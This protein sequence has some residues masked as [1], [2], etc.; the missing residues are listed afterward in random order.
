M[1]LDD[2]IYSK[3]YGIFSAVLS[4]KDFKKCW[5]RNK[6]ILFKNED[7]QQNKKFSLL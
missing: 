2:I 4:R 5:Y 7:S 3:E 6:D 1:Y